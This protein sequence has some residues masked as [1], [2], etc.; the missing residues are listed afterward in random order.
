M[1]RASPHPKF[2]KLL[3]CDFFPG[4]NQKLQLN[5]YSAPWKEDLDSDSGS[6]LDIREEDRIGSVIITMDKVSAAAGPSRRASGRI[7]QHGCSV[8]TRPRQSDGEEEEESIVS[9]RRFCRVRVS[10]RLVAF[11]LFL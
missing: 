11:R 8:F 3:T 2:T 7:H 9:H 10:V 6:Q 1:C 4:R 5:I